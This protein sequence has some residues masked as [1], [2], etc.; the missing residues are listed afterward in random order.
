MQITKI[1]RNYNV[2]GWLTGFVA[3]ALQSHRSYQLRTVLTLIFLIETP[4]KR[5][6]RCEN[7]SFEPLYIK[8]PQNWSVALMKKRI[9]TVS[10]KKLSRNVFH[11]CAELNQFN[12]SFARTS[13]NS[14]SWANI[15]IYLK[16][17]PYQL[18][19]GFWRGVGA[20]FVV[21]HWL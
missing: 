2:T 15:V 13:A 1:R 8:S 17:Y 18:V 16:P 20:N 12:P 4:I 14:A 11:M 19:Q 6:S 9:D 5:H 10:L 3:V 7:T 21:S